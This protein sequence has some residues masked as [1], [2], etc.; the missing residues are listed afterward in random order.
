MEPCPGLAVTRTCAGP[1]ANKELMD[2]GKHRA[3]Y[4]E[5][6]KHLPAQRRSCWTE[7]YAFCGSV[8]RM[9]GGMFLSRPNFCSRRPTNSMPTI[10][11][12]RRN[13]H[14]S[15]WSIPPV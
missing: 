6:T 7:A 12:V 10:D 9:Y 14:R 2:G 13:P 3:R 1:H 11:R 8:K 5:V 15:S 4:A